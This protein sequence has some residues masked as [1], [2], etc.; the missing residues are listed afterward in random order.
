MS[1]SLGLSY[2]LLIDAFFRVMSQKWSRCIRLVVSRCQFVSLL[3][4]TFIAWLRWCQHSFISLWT[5]CRIWPVGAPS[6]WFLCL[7][8]CPCHSLK[9]SL[10]SGTKR[11]RFLL[12][13]PCPTPGLSHFSKKP[14]FHLVGKNI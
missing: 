4:L 3:A 12:H 6:C 14:W 9:A 2:V 7:L 13:F 11:S 1:C 5:H 10:L 8:P